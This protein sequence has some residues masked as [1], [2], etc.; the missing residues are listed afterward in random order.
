MIIADYK[1]LGIADIIMDRKRANA[2]EQYKK[3]LAEV[4]KE[5]SGQTADA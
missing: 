2:L 4:E 5:I 3:D 1:S